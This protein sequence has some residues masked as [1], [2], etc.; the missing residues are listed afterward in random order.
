M[1]R[2]VCRPVETLSLCPVRGIAPMM[3]ALVEVMG[4][5]RLVPTGA[6]FW[7]HGGGGGAYF[8]LWRER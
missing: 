2:P 3:A 1:L 7:R 8:S 4:Q 5:R 6:C